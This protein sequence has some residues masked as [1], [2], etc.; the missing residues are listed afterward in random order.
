MGK[1]TT[2]TTAK[3]KKNKK[4]AEQPK[5]TANVGIDVTIK[6]NGWDEQ[7]INTLPLKKHKRAAKLQTHQIE[8]PLITNR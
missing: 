4:K 8:K 3:V 6:C 5:L 7:L 2:T 1:T